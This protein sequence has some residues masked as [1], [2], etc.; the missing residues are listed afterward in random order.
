M[1]MTCNK[2]DHLCHC[3]TGESSPH[4]ISKEGCVR[5]FVQSPFPVDYDDPEDY[6][7]ADGQKVTYYTLIEQ[8]GYYR[9][10]CGCW[11]RSPGSVN[12]VEG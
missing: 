6:W 4:E 10:P 3:G 12:S 11:S 5:F 1:S 8:R 7:I 2:N 9:H